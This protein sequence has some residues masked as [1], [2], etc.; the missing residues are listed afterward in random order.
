MPDEIEA[1]ESLAASKGIAFAMDV[2]GLDGLGNEFLRLKR[3]EEQYQTALPIIE[4]V[5]AGRVG[6]AHGVLARDLLSNPAERQ[7]S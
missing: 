3:L 2:L 5:A 6:P 4:A 7:Q 1:V